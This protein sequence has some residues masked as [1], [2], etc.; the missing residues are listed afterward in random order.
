MSIQVLISTYDDSVY[1]AGNVLA[2]LPEHVPVLMVHQNPESKKYRY[3]KIFS[4][5]NLTI[6]PISSRGLAKSRNHAISVATG[7]ILIPTDDDVTFMPDAMSAIE[8]AFAER[9]D[10]QLISFQALDED[11]FGHKAYESDRFRHSLNTIRRIYSI[12]IA[13][14]RESYSQYGLMWDEDFGLNSRYPGGLE[15]AYLKN[16]ID[17]KLPAYYEPQP[18]V[19]HPRIAT[20]Y[21]HS[22]ESG[23]F[24]GAVYAKMFGPFAY[25]L[26]AGFAGKNAWR[27][28]SFLGSLKYTKELYRGANDFFA[29]K[30]K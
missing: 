5:T 4:R 21:N 12:E 7:D 13:I 27:T 15:Q 26:L 23:F 25:P 18:I 28:G 24:R 2:S 6:S 16:L 3:D 17:L 1:R 11:G 20:G 10:A 8:R 30:K 22:P 9:S 19:I 29:R 14:R